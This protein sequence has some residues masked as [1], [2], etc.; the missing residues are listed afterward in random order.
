[1]IIG[2]DYNRTTII[3]G[4]N[5]DRIYDYLQNCCSLHLTRRST[6]SHTFVKRG[7]P[8][9]PGRSSTSKENIFKTLEASY[10]STIEIFQCIKLGRFK[11]D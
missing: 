9:G 7:R 1:M 8:H 11:L 10:F 5:R 3:C 6:K 2:I 4:T